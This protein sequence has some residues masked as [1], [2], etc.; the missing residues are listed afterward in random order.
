MVNPSKRISY[1]LIWESVPFF[2]QS[3]YGFENVALHTFTKY[4]FSYTL[5]D[6]LNKWLNI[7]F[8]QLR[9]SFHVVNTSLVKNSDIFLYFLASSLEIILVKV[10][11]RSYMMKLQ[12]WMVWERYVKRFITEWHWKLNHTISTNCWHRIFRIP[13]WCNILVAFCQN[14]SWFIFL[15]LQFDAIFFTALCSELFPISNFEMC[16]LMI[17]V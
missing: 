16:I 8:D 2:G 3:W 14:I 10:K 7:P 5:S 11:K 6:W 13:F 17:D 4:S 15:M 12:T 1:W 9:N